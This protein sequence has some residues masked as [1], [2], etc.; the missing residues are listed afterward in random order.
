MAGQSFNSNGVTATSVQFNV[1]NESF[2]LYAQWNGNTNLKEENIF[3]SKQQRKINYIKSV[4]V[5]YTV[6]P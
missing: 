4:Y 2:A 6:D 5:C 1:L 3:N